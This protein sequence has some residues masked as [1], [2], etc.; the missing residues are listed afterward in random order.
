MP[1]RWQLE[2]TRERT[3]QYRPLV[4]IHLPYNLLRLH[5]SGLSFQPI[6]PNTT[7]VRVQ[8][9][10][11]NSLGRSTPDLVPDASGGSTFQGSDGQRHSAEGANDYHSPVSSEDVSPAISTVLKSD[12][13]SHIDLR[14]AMSFLTWH[15]L[16]SPLCSIA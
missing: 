2:E 16:P 11:R 4:L 15:R 10:N 3:T 9:A 8:M 13:R 5:S 14:M 12:V 1:Q 6:I 7:S